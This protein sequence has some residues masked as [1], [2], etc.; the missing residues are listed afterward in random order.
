MQENIRK[1]SQ[2]QNKEG[3]L[4]RSVEKESLKDLAAD[5]KHSHHSFDRRESERRNSRDKAKLRRESTH[6]DERDKE[7]N[8][9]RDRRRSRSI[10]KGD[11]RK[12]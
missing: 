7:R 6:I 1:E 3:D 4:V 8:K 5:E 12:R 9:D 10:H 11:V 2:Q